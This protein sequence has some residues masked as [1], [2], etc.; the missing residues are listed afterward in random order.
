MANR[1]TLE[2]VLSLMSEITVSDTDV[3]SFIGAANTFVTAYLGT[4]SLSSAVLEEIERWMTA[5]MIAST[6]E[7]MATEEGAGGAYIKYIGTFA[8]ALSSTPYGQMVTT[9]D[10]TGTLAKIARKVLSVKAIT[11]TYN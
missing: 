1:T 6:R 9:L 7:R 2:R 3:E 4:S 5:H 8:D 10:T 11:T